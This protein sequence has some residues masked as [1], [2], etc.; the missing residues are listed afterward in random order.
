MESI[1]L[2]FFFLLGLAMGSFL[3]VVGLRLGKEE[4]LSREE[5]IVITAIMS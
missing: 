3:C 1:Y 4:D 2:I 5:V